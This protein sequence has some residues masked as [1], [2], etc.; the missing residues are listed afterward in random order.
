VT[1]ILFYVSFM[2]GGT[3]VAYFLGLLVE[4]EWGNVLG[5]A[6]V[7]VGSCLDVARQRKA[8]GMLIRVAPCMV[9]ARSTDPHPHRKRLIFRRD[10]SDSD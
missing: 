8:H 10:H 9:I 6:C 2:I 1:L 5:N 7:H 4:Y 3:F